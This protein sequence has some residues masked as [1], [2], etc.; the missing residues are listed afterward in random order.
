LLAGGAAG[1]VALALLIGVE[2]GTDGGRGVGQHGPASWRAGRRG[3]LPGSIPSETGPRVVKGQPGGCAPATFRPECIN[4]RRAAPGPC[5]PE[6]CRLVP[7]I[8]LTSLG[9][10]YP[11]RTRQATTTATT[12]SPADDE[13]RSAPNRQIGSLVLRVD[14]VG[15]GRIWAAHVGCVVDPEGSRRVPS[16]RL[17][18]QKDDQASQAAPGRR[19]SRAQDSSS[20]AHPFS[21]FP[22]PSARGQRLRI[23]AGSTAARAGYLLTGYGYS[24]IRHGGSRSR[25]W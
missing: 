20:G 12:H 8:P 4:S 24:P 23:H 13:R 11:Q 19:T 7:A 17:D 2:L 3:C 9:G 1:G 15:S 22:I 16:D 14:P 25:A 21:S 5:R 18:D 6:G 10:R